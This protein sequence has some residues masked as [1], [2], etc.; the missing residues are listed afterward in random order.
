MGCG[1]RDWRLQQRVG[2]EGEEWRRGERM[3]MMMGSPW[4][5]LL[6]LA[7]QEVQL[8]AAAAAA[9]AI[10]PHQRR[11]PVHVQPLLPR[12]D[13]DQ[14]QDQALQAPAHGGLQRPHL[15]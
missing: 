8:G 3:M 2:D 1:Q 9:R 15:P 12:H 13:R 6:P 11:Q 5:L 10:G 4:H 14:D 7:L